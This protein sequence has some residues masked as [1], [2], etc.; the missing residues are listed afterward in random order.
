M[1]LKTLL[2]TVCAAMVA[3]AV[4]G[5]I[6]EPV[7]WK[8]STV[9]QGDGVYDLNMT[10]TIE[11]HFHMYDMGPYVDGPNAT[12]VTVA[13]TP[14]VSLVGEVTTSIKPTRGFDSGFGMEVGYF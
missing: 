11:N 12:A 13:P 3:V 7:V 2:L 1:R 6:M 10:A 9:S 8:Q 5:Q 14:G 4:N